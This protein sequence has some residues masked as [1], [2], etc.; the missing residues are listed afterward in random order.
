MVARPVDLL[1]AAP[2]QPRHTHLMLLRTYVHTAIFRVPCQSA[3]LSLSC[4]RLAIRRTASVH[5]QKPA[6][7][8][9]YH[10]VEVPIHPCGSGDMLASSILERAQ[11][12]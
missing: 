12:Q 10:Y 8:T 2:S 7:G 1:L 4:A 3:H 5:F 6:R 9:V 11:I